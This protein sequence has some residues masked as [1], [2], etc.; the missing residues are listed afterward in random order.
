MNTEARRAVFAETHKA[1]HE[2]AEYVA[3][4]LVSSESPSLA[5]PPGIELSQDELQAL[6]EIRVRAQSAEVLKKL[7]AEA[8]SQPVF[9]LLSLL[10]GVTEP[11]VIEVPEWIGGSLET[12]ENGLMLHDEFFDTYL[13]YEDNKDA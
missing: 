1:I 4:V 8:C 13:D 10:D 9:H 5:Y 12:D 2:A 3:D 7:I 6:S 11:Y